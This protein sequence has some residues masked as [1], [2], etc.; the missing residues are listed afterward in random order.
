MDQEPS[1]PNTLCICGARGAA[2][3][4]QPLTSPGHGGAL[5]RRNPTAHPLRVSC[6]APAV[7]SIPVNKSFPAPPQ[8]G[9]HSALQRCWGVGLTLVVQTPTRPPF[10]CSIQ[11]MPF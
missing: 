10:C 1:M 3:Q 7:F 8:E 4:T 5:L 11:R 9:N 6:L 2:M